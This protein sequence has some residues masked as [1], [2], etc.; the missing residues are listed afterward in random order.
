MGPPILTPLV[1][2]VCA[3]RFDEYRAIKGLVAPNCEVS[4]VSQSAASHDVALGFSR[5]SLLS[6]ASPANCCPIRFRLVDGTPRCHVEL[7]SEH[8][9]ACIKPVSASA[10]AATIYHPVRREFLAIGRDGSST[11]K[12]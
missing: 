6:H 8:S 7:S 3:I 11:V 2:S 4:L 9:S 1:L 10:S 12:C 5:A